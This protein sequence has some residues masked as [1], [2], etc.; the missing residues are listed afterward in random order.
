MYENLVAVRN[1]QSV[2]TER[3][4]GQIHSQFHFGRLDSLLVPSLRAFLEDYLNRVRDLGER[5]A[6]DFLISSSPYTAG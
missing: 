1:E 5:I 6:R 4:A 3:L 2:E